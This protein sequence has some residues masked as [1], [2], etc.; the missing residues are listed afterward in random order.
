MYMKKVLL[1][2]CSAS[3]YSASAQQKNVFDINRHISN[4]LDKKHE[5]QNNVK[6]P[7]SVFLS[8]N[9]GNG[10]FSKFSH[11]TA[12]G[13]EVFILPANN[14]PCVVNGINL[15]NIPNISDP[16]KYYD[17][18]VFKDESPGSIP[19]VVKPYRVIPSK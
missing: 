5:Q 16:G 1:L 8:N 10:P 19:N 4:F 13:E 6:P 3:F 7:E 15:N 12:N 2:F 17:S 14:M 11:V 18:P 9:N